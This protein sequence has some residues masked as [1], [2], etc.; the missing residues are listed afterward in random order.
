MK[1]KPGDMI[2]INQPIK[3]YTG[4]DSEGNS[5]LTA[6]EKK[7]RK[8]EDAEELKSVYG[9]KTGIYIGEKRIKLNDRRATRKVIRKLYQHAK[10]GPHDVMIEPK[11]F[12]VVFSLDLKE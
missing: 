12:S 6:V 10:F 8:D 5:F 4:F 2:A 11:F 3:V 7:V 1:V 9:I